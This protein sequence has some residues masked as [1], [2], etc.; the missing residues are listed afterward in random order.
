M[1]KTPDFDEPAVDLPIDGTL[2]LHSFQPREV[3]ELIPAYL[4]LCC[5]RGILSIRI[6]HGKGTGTLR[7]LVHATL[8]KLPYVH[9]FKLADETG[10][11]WG[12]TIVVLKKQDFR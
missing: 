11:G 2:D 3:K 6:V 4:E 1:Q 12:A 8:R 7:E 9:D 10:G 5:H